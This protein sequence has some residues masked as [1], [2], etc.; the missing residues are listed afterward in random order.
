MGRS[1]DSPSHLPPL[2]SPASE[3]DTGIPKLGLPHEMHGAPRAP[4]V[5]DKAGRVSNRESQLAKDITWWQVSGRIRYCHGLAKEKQLFLFLPFPPPAHPESQ[6][7]AWSWQPHSEQ[8][9]GAR[10]KDLRPRLSPGVIGRSEECRSKA[11]RENL[12][13]GS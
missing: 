1:E 5:R 6:E 2:S 7:R 8:C 3:Q 13:L 12:G 10:G 9:G 11:L 4:P